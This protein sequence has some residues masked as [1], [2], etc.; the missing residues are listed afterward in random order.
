MGFRNFQPLAKLLQL[1]SFLELLETAVRHLS[2]ALD[3]TAVRHVLP[4]LK[5]L[6]HAT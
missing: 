2:L 5:T 1:D 4:G 6:T 3:N